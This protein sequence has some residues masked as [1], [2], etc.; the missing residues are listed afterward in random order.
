MKNNHKNQVNI[1]INLKQTNKQKKHFNFTM[2]LEKKKC[3]FP[4]FPGFR[5]CPILEI[6]NL[7]SFRLLQFFMV[8]VTSYGSIKHWKD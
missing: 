1:I 5:F 3:P 2:W 7:E 4:R 6:E 8:L